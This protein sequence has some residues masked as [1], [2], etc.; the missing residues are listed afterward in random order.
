VERKGKKEASATPRCLESG[1]G[2]NRKGKK[3]KGE[4]RWWINR[5]SSGKGKE[6]KEKKK[7]RLRPLYN[8]G[9]KYGTNKEGGMGEKEKKEK[10]CSCTATRGKKGRGNVLSAGLHQVIGK[11]KHKVEENRARK[12]KGK[13]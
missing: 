4:T 10:I 3:K 6:K 1:Y 12:G 5:I 7:E 8:Q 13:K 2:K 9:Y 11:R